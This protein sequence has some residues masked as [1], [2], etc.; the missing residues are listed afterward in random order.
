[1]IAHQLIT[2]SD[3]FLVIVFY[4]IL[5]TLMKGC[6]L[7]IRAFFQSRLCSRAYSNHA[8]SVAFTLISL[9][10]VACS[11]AYLQS[12]RG[13]RTYSGR[14]EEVALRKTVL[15]MNRVHVSRSYSSHSL[16]KTG[17]ALIPVALGQCAPFQ[18]IHLP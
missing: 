18:S 10:P 14:A 6:L 7:C 3:Y 5:R 9:F 11:R 17:F 8:W 13:S 16:A 4:N 2:F 15:L 1:M 12:R